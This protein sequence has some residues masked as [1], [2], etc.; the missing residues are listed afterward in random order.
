VFSTSKNCWLRARVTKVEEEMVTLVYQFPDGGEGTKQLPVGH[1]HLRLVDQE[2]VVPVPQSKPPQAPYQV[3][4]EAQVFSA[5]KNCWL[6]ARVSKIEDGLVT[7]IYKFP[8]GG[9]GTKQL[10]V[11][12][13]HLKPVEEEKKDSGSS[14]GGP[15]VPFQSGGNAQVFSESNN[16]WLRARVT[17]VEGEMVTL[18]Y[19]FPHGGDELNSFQQVMSI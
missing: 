18:V 9:G 7:L 13:N 1:E 4:G 8:D 3:D 17:K 11:D 6:R 2:D 10:P 15:Q 12:H 16:C 5:S 19:K 14:P